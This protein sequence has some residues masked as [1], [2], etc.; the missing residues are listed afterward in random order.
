MVDIIDAL[1]Y[2]PGHTRE[3]L[4]RALRIPALAKGWQGSFQA[5]LEQ[6]SSPKTAA[7]NPGLA[8]EG[9]QPPAWPGFRP[10]ARCAISARKAIA[11]NFPSDWSQAAGSFFLV[12][13][14]G[15]FVVSC[16]CVS[17]QKNRRFFRS[18]SLGRLIC[19]KPIISRISVTDRIER[20]W[21][22]I[23]VQPYAVRRSIGC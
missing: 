15:Q 19:R 7:G 16:G 13:Q 1:L 3:Q 6:D 9:M 23:S 8:Y 21:K 18:Y 4:Q 14:A 11:R 12:F 10:D 20:D 2:L 5:M 17:T 22:F